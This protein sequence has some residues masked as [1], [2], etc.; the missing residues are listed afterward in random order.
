MPLSHSSFTFYYIFMKHIYLISFHFLIPSL[1]RNCYSPSEYKVL[2]IILIVI[3]R[4][5]FGGHNPL[6]VW[7]CFIN[8]SEIK[9]LLKRQSLLIELCISTRCLYFKQCSPQWTLQLVC[10]VFTMFYCSL[11]LAYVSE[12]LRHFSVKSC[13]ET[14][15]TKYAQCLLLVIYTVMQDNYECEFLINCIVFCVT[16]TSGF[17][18]SPVFKF[19]VG[20]KPGALHS[21]TVQ[22]C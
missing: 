6:D 1:I 2:F 18:G 14:K 5:Q 11:H 10:Y 21:W 17:G 15:C 22:Y 19:L 20:L 9:A 7:K 13:Q 16:L 8:L 3:F 4:T 12:L